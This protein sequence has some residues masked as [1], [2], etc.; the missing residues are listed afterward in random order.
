[1]SIDLDELKGNS[2]ETRWDK[3]TR[4]DLFEYSTNKEIRNLGEGRFRII[5]LR[6]GYYRVEVSWHNQRNS[7]KAGAFMVFHLSDSWEHS[8]KFSLPTSTVLAL[9]VHLALATIEGVIMDQESGDP[10]AGARMVILP[11]SEDRKGSELEVKV[12]DEGYFLEENIPAGD[13]ILAVFHDQYCPHVE[14]HFSLD[15]NVDQKDLRIGLKPGACT[16]SG[17][18]NIADNPKRVKIAWWNKAEWQVAARLPSAGGYKFT[19]CDVTQDGQF[20][21]KGLPPG[22][23]TL[24]VY[25]CGKKNQ[26][27]PVQL[28]WPAEIPFEIE[29]N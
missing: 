13:Y 24:V 25:Y 11:E 4:A 1:M 27:M 3:S 28:P 2:E 7:E 26:E 6:A 14:E 23:M 20:T 22:P 29:V 15:D 19:T 12:N 10:L 21:L 16:L 17:K 9:E 18:L 8:E 5:D